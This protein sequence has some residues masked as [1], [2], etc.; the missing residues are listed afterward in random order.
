MWIVE[1]MDLQIEKMVKKNDGMLVTHCR[2]K[3][4]S[5]KKETKF[6][7][8]NDGPVNFAAV[9]D[10]YLNVIICSLGHFRGRVFFKGTPA[11]YA[12]QHMGKNLV[13]KVPCKMA[14]VLGLDN[15]VSF[16][17]H[18]LRR[19]SAAAAADSGASVQQLM[20]FYGW[21]NPSMPQE[22]VSSS[23]ASVKS[24][25]DKLQGPSNQVEK[26]EVSEVSIENIE[27][28]SSASPPQS[29]KPYM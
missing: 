10:D 7:V 19:L 4:R 18:S 29:R 25:A 8:P 1:L 20:D 22:C 9:I 27:T 28:C 26:T 11:A 12:D 6:L 2:S 16:T 21:S 5:D 13:S 3:Q 15:P 14:T 23:K 17:F 24:M